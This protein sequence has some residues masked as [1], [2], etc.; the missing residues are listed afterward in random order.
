MPKHFKSKKKLRHDIF[1]K[2]LIII[3]ISYIIIKL[4]LLLVSTTPL[5]K[6]SFSHNKLH[7]YK[8]YVTSLTLNHPSYMLTYYQEPSTK[9]SKENNLKYTYI[10]NNQKSKPLIYIYNTHQ[11]EGY[12]GQKTVLDAAKSMKEAFSKYKVD[13]LVEQRDITEFM[14]ANNISY[15]YSYYASKFY[16]Q[17][18]LAKNKLD[19]LIDL[20]RD[21]VPKNVSTVKI[22]NKQYAKIMF[23]VGMEH[24]KYKVN[25]N[26]A[27]TLNNLIKKKY[28]TLTRGV[29]LKSGKNVNGIYNQNLSSNIILIELG[30]N[31]NT[32]DEVNNTIGLITKIIGEYLYEK[33]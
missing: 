33:K 1:I 23:V 28:P 21:A 14:R 32:Y 15:N 11:Q 2:Y 26:L 24:A 7:D 25:Y 10:N 27:T 20:H 16:V 4:C 29:I 5:L 8:K 9:P 6:L 13:V 19:L 30:G 12:V 22:G 18:A 31:Y 17:D 3:I